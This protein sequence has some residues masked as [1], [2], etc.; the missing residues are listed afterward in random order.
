MKFEF[1]AAVPENTGQEYRGGGGVL[2]EQSGYWSRL[3]W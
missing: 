1:P 3:G 2:P